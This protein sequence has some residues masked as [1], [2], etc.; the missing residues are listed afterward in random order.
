MHSYYYKLHIGVLTQRAG[1]S[2][3][4]SFSL[5][6]SVDCVHVWNCKALYYALP[7]VVDDDLCVSWIWRTYNEFIDTDTKIQA[8][9]MYSHMSWQMMESRFA[10]NNVRKYAWNRSERD[11]KT[12]DKIMKAK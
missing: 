3:F 7:V 2:T 5:E 6:T 4:S 10:N 9:N 12:N 11:R 1:V 8:N